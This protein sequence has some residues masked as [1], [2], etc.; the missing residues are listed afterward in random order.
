MSTCMVPMTF[1]S[2]SRGQAAGGVTVMLYDLPVNL[3]PSQMV[4]SACH[5][6]LCDDDPVDDSDADVDDSDAEVDADDESDDDDD[7]DTVV[8]VAVV[9]ESERAESAHAS[10]RAV[11]TMVR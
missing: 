11:Q 3:K 2:V 6:L 8:V 7:D 4:T 9:V 5:R 10:F 1:F